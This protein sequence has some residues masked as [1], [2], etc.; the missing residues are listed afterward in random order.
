MATGLITPGGVIGATGPGFTG[1][2]G[3]QGPQG[4]TGA[5]GPQGATGATGPQGPQGPG[6]NF[7]GTGINEFTQTGTQLQLPP[8][9]TILNYGTNAPVK[10]LIA[11]LGVTGS[12]FKTIAGISMPTGGVYDWAISVA[13]TDFVNRV[14]YYRGDLTFTIAQASGGLNTLNPTGP[15]ISNLRSG[16]TGAGYQC[17]ATLLSYPTGIVSIQVAGV[18][19]LVNWSLIGQGQQVS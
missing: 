15:T 10:A 8:S 14:N 19:G 1:P 12:S 9:E 11:A 17:I 4:V 3:A 13:A 16:Q 6:A 7:S 18:T 2:T 5:T